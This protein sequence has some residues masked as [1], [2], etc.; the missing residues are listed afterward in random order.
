M[1][2][3]RNRAPSGRALVRKG[4]WTAAIGAVFALALTSV[5][6]EVSRA[7]ARSAVHRTATS[8]TKL[9]SG[10]HDTVVFRGLQRPTTIAF[11]KDGRIF[12]AEQAGKIEVYQSLHD[13]KPTLFADLSTDVNSMWERG[14]LGLA[15]A[16]NFPKDP[17][18][19][20]LY[21]RDALLGGHS[22]QWNDTCPTPPGMLADGCVVSGR[23]AR[24][25]A[26]GNH[27]AGKPKVLIDD[28]CQQ[29]PS[30]SIGTVRFGPDGALYVSG[31]EGA[32]FLKPDW[33]QYGESSQKSPTPRNPCGDP[34]AGVG[35]VERPPGAE[36]GSLR[37]QSLRRPAGQ[38]VSLD[39]TVIRVD[40]NTGAALP[41]NPLARDKNA[42]ARRIIAYGLRNPYRFTF[43]PGTEEIWLGDVG[44][45]LWEEI[46]R[47]P[48]LLG[49]HV[50]NF[51]WPCYEGPLS[52]PRFAKLALCKTL[53]PDKTVYPY[54]AYN[55]W[56]PAVRGDGC[57]VKPGAAITGLAF[58]T[59]TRY[60]ARF[61]NGLFFADY[62][63]G[64]IWFMP[65]G[66]NGLPNPKRAQIFT[67]AAAN[68]VDLETGPGGDLFY[69]DII[70]G[71]IHR[72][73]YST[74]KG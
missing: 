31:G 49:S 27:M 73:T 13:R 17:Y 10:F 4:L 2:S 36:G 26:D 25:R 12:V 35:G 34:P 53:P 37:A 57:S 7:Q 67:A 59:G 15:L 72:I 45:F 43:R 63:R 51:G 66:K 29:F 18:V 8:L 6:F 22:P 47:I 33:G 41:T 55:H 28:W 60:P 56:Q 68:P 48:N 19:Y 52:H 44:E 11:A 9:P 32:A 23:L 74:S 46:D 42:N 5:G 64:C 39:G 38:P 3:V 71:T 69:A 62:T 70:D 50:P 65:A 24:L 1:A 40:P 20:V 21:T 30:H 14:L 58:Y 61:R 16:P 54:F